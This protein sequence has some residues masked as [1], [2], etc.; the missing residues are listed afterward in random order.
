M[1]HVIRLTPAPAIID[2]LGGAAFLA[3]TGARVLTQ[4]PHW[5]QIRL[6]EGH[7]RQDITAVLVRRDHDARYTMFFSRHD[8]HGLTPLSTHAGLYPERLQPVFRAET[9]LDTRLDAA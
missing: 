4:G 9:G 2:L 1:A 3:A 5:L 6:P 7:A 8:S